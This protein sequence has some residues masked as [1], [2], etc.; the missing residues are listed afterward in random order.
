M[1]S[2][3]KILSASAISA[4]VMLAS[5]GGQINKDTP[6]KNDSDSLSYAFGTIMAAQYKETGKGLSDQ[7]DIQLNY[8]AFL[9][10]LHSASTNDTSS[11]KFKSP[12]E[13]N[14]YAESVMSQRQ[15]TK[16]AKDMEEAKKFFDENAKKEGVVTLEN[17]LQY[18]ILE[19]GNGEKP[20]ITDTVLCD[21]VGTLV[22]GTEFDSSI[23][24]GEPAKFPLNRVISG[25]TE[26]IQMMPKGSKWKLFIPSEYG[27]GPQGNPPVIPPNA[28][29]I[30]EVKLIDIMKGK[31]A[32]K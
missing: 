19:E 29:L 12:M 1:K 15:Q 21:Y 14:M 3:T 28:A 30:F 4:S 23:K 5:C 10:G 2:L 16:M 11:M 32:G 25:W 27:Y 22:D 6:L 7:F 13:A 9:A 8:E 26:L 20:E 24:R 17:G 18:Q 31:P